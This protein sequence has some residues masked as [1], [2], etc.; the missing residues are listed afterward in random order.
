MP[1][2]ALPPQ[3][4]VKTGSRL[5]PSIKLSAVAA[6]EA[7]PVEAQPVQPLTQPLLERYWAETAKELG[8]EE[9]MAPR[10]VK[11][12]GPEG[13]EIE[14]TTPWFESTFKQSQV[15][16]MQ[17]LRQ[18]SGVPSLGCSIVVRRQEQEAKAYRP[19]DKYEAMVAINPA[20]AGLRKIFTE[21]D[22]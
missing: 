11:L 9:L 20:L 22:Y 19:A 17:R 10:T 3:P 18:K 14:A 8:L 7:R 6:A 21:I 2:S 5:T 4:P 16:V 15:A 1:L 13:F 12:T